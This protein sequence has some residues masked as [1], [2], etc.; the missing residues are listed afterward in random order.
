MK[1]LL[2]ILVVPLLAAGAYAVG[3][4]DRDL[5]GLQGN[6]VLESLQI[7]G[8]S[9]PIDS[10]K[11]DKKPLA[12]RLTVKGERYTLYLADRPLAMTC[13]V[14]SG[15][16]PWWITLTMLEGTDKGKAFR[17]IFKLEGDRFTICRPLDAVHPRPTTF[18]TAANS[19]LML[20]VWKRPK[21]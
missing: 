13:R 5:K 10:L 11:I 12:P 1:R 18:A 8:E 4:T 7:N 6:W 9:I 19:G 17:G 3:P 20:G 21:P 14:D 15:R 2:M 16:S